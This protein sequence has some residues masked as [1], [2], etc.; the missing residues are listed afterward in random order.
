MLIKKLHLTH[1]RCF[2]Q[3]TIAFHPHIN[4]FI[5]NN[6]TGKTALL[7]AARI[8]LGAWFIG[9][10]DLP[11]FHIRPEDIQR[12]FALRKGD[13]SAVKQYP[14][15]VECEGQVDGSNITWSRSKSSEKGRTNR[16]GAKA[17]TAITKEEDRK[18]RQ[19]QSVVLPLFMYFEAGRLWDPGSDDF[20]DTGDLTDRL[21]GYQNCLRGKLSREL[22][23][24]TWKRR[25]LTQL[26]GTDQPLLHAVHNALVDAIPDASS[27]Q[28]VT[29]LGELTVT[30]KNGKTLPLSLLSDGYRSTISML[31]EI[32]TRATFLNPDLGESAVRE[33]P[34][35]IL[36][37]EID[38]HLHPSWQRRILK[39]IRRVFPRMQVIATAHAPQVL[40]GAEKG[41]LQILTRDEQGALEITQKDV[42]PGYDVDQVL[43]GEWFGLLSTLDPETLKL[44]DDYTD[45]LRQQPGTSP[46]R[47]QLEQQLRDRLGHFAETSWERIAWSIVAEYARDIDISTQENRAKLR[48][49]AQ[50]AFR[51]EVGPAP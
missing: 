32:A 38:M 42:P 6:A 12:S 39:D 8:A 45:H 9:F 30:F 1:F 23:S 10:T 14:V 18:L 4:L 13:Y 37:D 36:I 27:I 15:V 33:T 20:M 21:A 44:L 43:T 34:G 41:E 40:V 47:A 28:Y 26:E 25:H 31:A 7:E 46:R 5:G 24:L 3:Q 35:V 2:E 11:S 48:E 50:K 22:V 51:Q 16:I 17:L 49:L 19:H 29:S